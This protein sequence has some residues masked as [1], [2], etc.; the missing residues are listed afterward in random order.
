MKVSQQEPLLSCCFVGHVSP[1]INVIS[2]DY[3]CV[4]FV[5]L[6]INWRHPR[7]FTSHTSRT[8]TLCIY[9]YINVF[10]W[11]FGIFFCSGRGSFLVL[12][13]L[14]HAGSPPGHHGASLALTEV[15]GTCSGG[16]K[17]Q[18]PTGSVSEHVEPSGPMQ[19]SVQ[20]KRM[21]DGSCIS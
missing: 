20:V 1:D 9:I 17:W 4:S 16:S 3:C 7:D 21:S 11:L 10:F 18:V 12:S 13:A 2:C 5:P 8:G 19:T 15:R 6:F 14:W